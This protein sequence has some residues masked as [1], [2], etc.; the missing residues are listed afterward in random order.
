M[1]T[2]SFEE[3]VA[4]IDRR[5]NKILREQKDTYEKRIYVVHLLKD[6]FD[7]LCEYS[8]FEVTYAFADGAEPHIHV[9]SNCWGWVNIGATGDKIEAHTHGFRSITTSIDD[10]AFQKIC[11]WVIKELREHEQRSMMG[12]LDQ[13]R[14]Q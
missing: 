1:K 2:T 8:L 9:E 7:H 6:I 3:I 13:A 14:Q 5:N 12:R 10:E 4:E 11:D